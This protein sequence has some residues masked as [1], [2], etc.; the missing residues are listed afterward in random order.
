MARG[1]VVARSR[2]TNGNVMGRSH[3]NP[4]LDPRI[5][6]VVFA[7]GDVTE[8]T[9]NVNL[10][11]NEYLLLDALVDYCRDNKVISLPDK[12]ITVQGRAVTSKTLVG[13]FAASKR[14][15]LPHGRSCS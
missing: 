2:D 10:E 14:T 7:E 5:Y 3:T 13:K 1:Y 6:Q 11:G 9:A 8:L 12:Q 15:V 4:I